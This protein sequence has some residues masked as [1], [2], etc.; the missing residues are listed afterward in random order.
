MNKYEIITIPDNIDMTNPYRLDTLSQ[1]DVSQVTYTP[2]MTLNPGEWTFDTDERA[3]WICPN[4]IVLS[5]TGTRGYIK[6]ID[7]GILVHPEDEIEVEFEIKFLGEAERQLVGVRT[8]LLDKNSALLGTLDFF[9]KEYL[10]E[11]Q[12]IKIRK[13]VNPAFT[14]VRN[15]S[16]VIGTLTSPLLTNGYSFKIRNIKVTIIKNNTFLDRN[17]RLEDVG[18]N[19][20]NLSEKQLIDSATTH[21]TTGARDITLKSGIYGFSGGGV[22]N[23]SLNGNGVLIVLPYRADGTATTHIIQ[24]AYINAADSSYGV[25]RRGYNGNTGEW[26]KWEALHNSKTFKIDELLRVGTSGSANYGLSLS[27]VDGDPAKFAY[28]EIYDHTNNRPLTGIYVYNTFGKFPTMT[29][30]KKDGTTVSKTIQPIHS[31]TTANRPKTA[32]YNL[33]VGYQYFDTT[34]GKPIWHK[35]YDVWVDAT[36]TIV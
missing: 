22:T 8:D 17:A 20:L 15:I 16:I 5:G 21:P 10:E 29:Y 9:V 28:L 18:L 19:K 33:D 11:Y 25:Y 3:Y 34:L 32:D 35:G 6:L 31:G 30:S 2:G 36:G 27:H 13:R 12:Q 23:G 24:I 7:K 1:E 26:T 14:S 4:T